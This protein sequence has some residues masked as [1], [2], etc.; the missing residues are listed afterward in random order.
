MKQHISA[1]WKC[2][3]SFIILLFFIGNYC[4]HPTQFTPFDAIRHNGRLYIQYICT[5][6]CWFSSAYRSRNKHIRSNFNG[7]LHWWKRYSLD[8]SG[9][10]CG[11]LL[12]HRCFW[13][14][15]DFNGACF[16]Q[17]RRPWSLPWWK[18]INSALTAYTIYYFYFGIELPPRGFNLKGL[19]IS[20]WLF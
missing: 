16:Y 7:K 3:W 9:P 4:Y 2:R 14:C 12:S 15:P 11:D 13:C 20:L 18:L 6:F 1:L 19:V 8:H 10:K 5:R 17:F